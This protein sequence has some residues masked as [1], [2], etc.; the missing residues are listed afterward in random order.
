MVFTG[1]DEVKFSDDSTAQKVALVNKSGSHVLP[2]APVLTAGT[3]Q[4]LNCVADKTDYNVTVVAG[5]VY[6]VFADNGRI[7]FG[8]AAVATASAIVDAAVLTTIP[9][10]GFDYFEAPSGQTTLHYATDSG[11]GITGRIA[12]VN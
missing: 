10:G 1:R 4:R 5:G 12:R 9:A 6:R 8:I 2:L 11:A 7:H 3:G